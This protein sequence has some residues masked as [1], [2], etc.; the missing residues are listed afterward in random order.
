MGRVTF[1]LAGV[2]ALVAV[3]SCAPGEL[4]IGDY[5]TTT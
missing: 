1:L 3:S 4:L 2:I 5:I